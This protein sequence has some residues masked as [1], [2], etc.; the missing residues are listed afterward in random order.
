M[1]IIRHNKT[2]VAPKSKDVGAFN[3]KK[4]K[5]EI[6]NIELSKF[7]TNNINLK[8]NL[9]LRQASEMLLKGKRRE[10]IHALIQHALKYH[11]E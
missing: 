9:D 3:I 1:P 10:A 8:R 2:L 7:L 11:E 4:M 5:E 6:E